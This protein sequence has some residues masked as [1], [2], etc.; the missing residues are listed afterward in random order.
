[1]Y[2]T[3]SGISQQKSKSINCYVSFFSIKSSSILI[4][5]VYVLTHNLNWQRICQHIWLHFD[6]INNIDFL[7]EHGREGS[8]VLM[9]G[10]PEMYYY[11][12]RGGKVR[13]A[14]YSVENVDVV[15]VGDVVFVG[16]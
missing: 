15:S 14:K 1:M 8:V 5:E 3:E 9:R 4:E 2:F 10:T 7:K 6:K 12:P 11:D 16:N 13:E